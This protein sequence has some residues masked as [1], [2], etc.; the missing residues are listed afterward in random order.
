MAASINFEAQM[1]ITLSL[2]QDI[3]NG[4]EP[5]S[6]YSIARHFVTMQ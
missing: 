1:A 4:E 3:S 6:K 5:S 2:E